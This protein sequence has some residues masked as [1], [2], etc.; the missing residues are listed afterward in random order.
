MARWH[1]LGLVVLLAGCSLD[2]GP[3]AITLVPS[4]ST[5]DWSPSRRPGAHAAAGSSAHDAGSADAS[6]PAKSED[7]GDDAAPPKA[8]DGNH[9]QLDAGAPAAANPAS[10]SPPSGGSAAVSSAQPMAGAASSA[11]AGAHAEPAADGGKGAPSR[12]P[13][14]SAPDK[15]E[16]HGEEG[17]SGSDKGEDGADSGR[18][19]HHHGEGS[20]QDGKRGR[21]ED[22]KPAEPST[23]GSS[24]T[25]S[26]DG[27]LALLFTTIS[28]LVYSILELSFGPAKPANI[29]NLVVSI[30]TLATLPA[31][32]VTTS[33]LADLLEQLDASN[34]CSDDRSSCESLCET[35][36]ASCDLYKSD[37]RSVKSVERNCGAKALDACK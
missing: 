6:K 30:V 18:G 28:N 32:E 9:T 25:Q 34:A 13:A 15:P 4:V 5:P 20:A 24:V 2:T 35:L 27:T 14:S 36:I 29:T 16:A 10:V 11:S 19:A 7:K 22:D 21:D 26:Q 8:A 12:P 31:S 1:G 17:K 37:P 3:N 23:G 33:T